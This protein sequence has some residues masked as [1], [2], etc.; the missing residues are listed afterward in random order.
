MLRV[1]L[2]CLLR[3]AVHH[4]WTGWRVNRKEEVEVD[5]VISMQQHETRFVIKTFEVLETTCLLD[6]VLKLISTI[7]SESECCSEL[8]IVP[9]IKYGCIL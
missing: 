7:V 3:T 6:F 2:G 1:A 4:Q 5:V 8:Q 9:K